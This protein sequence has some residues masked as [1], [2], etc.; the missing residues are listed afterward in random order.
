MADMLR[1]MNIRVHVLP[2]T[3]NYLKSNKTIMG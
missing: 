2:R 1:H 3:I